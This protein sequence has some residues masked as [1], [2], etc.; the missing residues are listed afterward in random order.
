M[1]RREGAD[2]KV[3]ALLYRVVIQAVTLL[4]LESWVLS[5]ALEKI[6]EG[7]HTEF[8]RKIMGKRAWRMVVVMW[9][10]LMV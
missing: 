6:V 2:T 3:V 7:A 9:V 4:G 1:L 10:T 8:L 5:K